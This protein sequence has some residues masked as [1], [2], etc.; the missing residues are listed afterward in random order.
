MHFLPRQNVNDA[1]NG[2]DV[3]TLGVIYDPDSDT[4]PASFDVCIQYQNCKTVNLL[5]EFKYTVKPAVSLAPSL[6][7]AGSTL[8]AVPGH[9]PFLN[10][11]YA[12]SYTDGVVT[13]Y[14]D[15]FEASTDWGDVII[16]FDVECAL[17]R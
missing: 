16:E 3:G 1:S 9:G 12:S 13:W 8:V 7:G 11:A 6:T 2:I 10:M 17:R 15:G 5:K 14:G 4:Y